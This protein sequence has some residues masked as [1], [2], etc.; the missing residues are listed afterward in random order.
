M[1]KL[2]SVFYLS[3][4]D[5]EIL[6]TTGHVTIEGVTYDYDENAMYITPD[7]GVS[8]AMVFE[9]ETAGDC[10]FDGVDTGVHAVIKING[11]VSPFVLTKADDKV[12]A[13][14]DGYKDDGQLI[15]TEYDEDDHQWYDNDYTIG[16][17]GAT[18]C[19][20]DDCF[21]L[22]EASGFYVIS[23]KAGTHTFTVTL[24]PS[25]SLDVEITL[26]EDGS[27]VMYNAGQSYIKKI[28]YSAP[29]F[30]VIKQED[31]DITENVAKAIQPY[32]DFPQSGMVLEQVGGGVNITWNGDITGK[33]H[34]SV[35]KG[36]FPYDFYKLSDDYVIS[37]E[38][39]AITINY[40][41]SDVEATEMCE[42][43]SIGDGCIIGEMVQEDYRQAVF[44]CTDGG[45]YSAEGYGVSLGAGTW[46]IHY[47][48]ALY[49]SKLIMGGEATKKITQEGADITED[50][51]E[52]LR[53]YVYT[54]GKGVNINEDGVI[55]TEASIVITASQVISTDPLK[56][57]LTNE[58]YAVLENENNNF[59]R[60]DATALGKGSCVFSKALSENTQRYI[61]TMQECNYITDTDVATEARQD[62]III[63][64]TSKIGT[65]TVLDLLSEN[66]IIDDV[67]H[68]DDDKALSA[69]MGHALNQEIMNLKNIGRFL[70]LWD[71]T[72]GLPT[73]NPVE[74]PYS[75]K[76]GDYYRVSKV[77]STG[78]VTYHIETIDPEAQ[79]PLSIDIVPPEG[80]V[81]ESLSALRQWLKDNGYIYFSSDPYPA[82]GTRGSTQ[83]MGISADSFMDMLFMHSDVTGAWG[84]ENYNE[85]L[86]LSGGPETNYKPNGSTYTGTPSSTEETDEVGIG[87]VY[88]YD[89]TVWA[90][91]ASSGGGKVQDV[92]LNGTSVLD[93][94]VA[95]IV[96]ATRFVSGTMSAVDKTKLD[97]IESEAEKNVLNGVQMAGT[98][99]TITNKKVNIPIAGNDLGVVKTTLNGSGGLSINGS[100]GMYIV[101]SSAAEIGAR[102]NGSKPIVPSNL[103]DA[104]VAG[105]T[106]SHHITLNDTQKATAQSVLGAGAPIEI[107]VW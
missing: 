36:G 43:V 1:S 67:S 54:A 7:D 35:T 18:K 34:G 30:G 88:Y 94:G 101:G 13:N 96:D 39:N 11:S 98:D 4:E 24:A 74:M 46:S 63:H 16:D 19:G 55:S 37:D 87:D 45:T 79:F 95:K 78:E 42:I 82:T 69:N 41:G 70:A 57:Q 99:L 83:I 59:I 3:N 44:V 89:G 64:R 31:V 23:G 15:Y 62:I 68:T 21:C 103:N 72:T 26:T 75:Y 52:I 29:S 32:I 97:N 81:W 17:L 107:E 100:G 60:C 102:T 86:A 49:V 38:I 5:Y 8:K 9:Q 51:A 76:T 104:L 80:V 73:T 47:P 25:I 56:I 2:N 50:T 6:R 106:D 20:T 90:K 14:P 84:Y 77:A 48:N 22:M 105:L 71:C 92:T 91:Q 53:P 33:T 85:Q 66:D 65:Y 61:L 27:Y 28:A 93:G 58:Q 40:A 12:R 10:E